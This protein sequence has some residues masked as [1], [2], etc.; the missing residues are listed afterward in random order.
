LTII[1]VT[2]LWALAGSMLQNLI[3]SLRSEASIRCIPIWFCKAVT[4]NQKTLKSSVSKSFQF[5]TTAN[6]AH[7]E[8]FIKYSRLSGGLKKN[9]Y[10]G[11]IFER[12]VINDRG[13]RKVKPE[14]ER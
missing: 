6:P 5:E 9:S 7:F 2:D 3:Y 4:V 1:T 14:W 8:A 12:K 11:D 13:K 10:S